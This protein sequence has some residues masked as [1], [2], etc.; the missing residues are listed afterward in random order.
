MTSPISWPPIY[1]V[2]K[3]ARAR[4]VKMRVTHEKGLELIVPKRFSLK[5]IPPILAENKSWI[6][7]KLQE[8]TQLRERKNATELPVKI[9]LAAIQQTWRVD[10]IACQTRLK[11]TQRPQQHEIV[12]FGDISDKSACQTLLKL[13][14]I[15]QAKL[16]LP[17]QLMQL[18]EKYQL[19]FSKVT[20]RDQQT[21]LGSC[22]SDKAINL[23]FRLILLAEE[24]AAHILIH[25]LCHTVHLNHTKQFWQWVAK[26]DPAWEHH[27]QQIRRL[28]QLLPDWLG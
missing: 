5:N 21:R 7:K 12:L 16:H 3:H 24:L 10:Y 26:C 27:K 4:Y 19:P 15:R 11:L 20:I 14:L 22:T 28:D 23:N 6:E 2:K 9:E 25:E 1:T 13:W 18:S 17:K 8:A